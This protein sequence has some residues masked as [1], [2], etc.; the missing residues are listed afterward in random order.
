MSALIFTVL[1]S[2]LLFVC[3]KWFDIKKVNLLMAIT[4]NYIGCMGTGLV[5]NTLMAEEAGLQH[6]F[7]TTMIFTCLCIGTLFFSVFYA[8]G[9][10]SAKIGV[11]ITS[12]STKMSLV[13][14]VLFGS[15]VLGEALGLRNLVALL[16]ALVAVVLMSRNNDQKLNLKSL[17]LPFLIFIGSGLVDTVI[18]V[19]RIELEKRQLDSG[20][21]III[22]FLGAFCSAMTVILIKDRHLL[23][24][25]RSLGYG[26]LLGIPNYLSIYFMMKALGSG[27]F[28]SNQ[29][30]MI[31]NTS[32][33]ILCFVAGLALFGEKINL[34]KGIG[35]LLSILSIYLILYS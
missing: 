31:N 30:Y 21:S 15:L 35:L 25:F 17:V 34:S 19:L 26:I 16:L 4:G 28:S 6:S 22:L 20:T 7:D 33:M 1:L 9:Y 11:G 14:P 12:A 32:V 2:A 24:D 5:F 23:K 3:F 18:N 10:A 8:M 29:F 27:E 13:L